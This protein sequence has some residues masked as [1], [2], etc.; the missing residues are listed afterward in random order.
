[1]ESQ[2]GVTDMD[3]GEELQPTNIHTTA[4][5][6]LH[7]H[8]YF[9]YISLYYLQYTAWFLMIFLGGTVIRWG[10]S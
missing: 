6:I 9:K 1:M 3:K 8:N 4:D 7:L 2:C 10:G 5:I